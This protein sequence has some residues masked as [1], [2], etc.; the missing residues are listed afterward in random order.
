MEPLHSGTPRDERGQRFRAGQHAVLS[1]NIYW[2]G[3]HPIP[4]QP[5]D[6][7]VP[8]RDPRKRLA[9]PLLGDPQ[10]GVFT[11]RWDAAKGRFASGQTTVSGEFGRLVRQYAVPVAENPYFP[12]DSGLVR[13]IQEAF[14]KPG[15]M[16]SRDWLV[17]ATETRAVRRQTGPGDVI[18]AGAAAAEGQISARA[19][20]AVDAPTSRC[21]EVG[22][23]WRYDMVS[24][25]VGETR[26][27]G[28]ADIPSSANNRFSR[29][30]AGLAQVQSRPATRAAQGSSRTPNHPA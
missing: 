25:C 23:H 21:G 22:T 17:Y 11:P 10:G 8:D 26:I 20:Q 15:A 9:D 29:G 12:R 7:L 5:G 24:D 4:T 14:V 2:N 19:W 3:G 13:V 16:T 1:N 6:V 27:R 30:S 18:D 28:P